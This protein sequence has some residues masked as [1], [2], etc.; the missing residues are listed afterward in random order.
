MANTQSVLCIRQHPSKEDTVQK[1]NGQPF[2]RCA[3]GDDRTAAVAYVRLARGERAQVILVV[4]R[5]ARRTGDLF[6]LV[7]GLL[8]DHGVDEVPTLER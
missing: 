4:R 6:L 3:S 2:R 1:P 7:C 5:F 8:V